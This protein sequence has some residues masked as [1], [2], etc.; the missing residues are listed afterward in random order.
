MRKIVATIACLG[1]TEIYAS[2]E[3]QAIDNV[4]KLVEN[5]QLH[6]PPVIPVFEISEQSRE[7]TPATE[8]SSIDEKKDKSMSLEEFIQQNPGFFGNGQSENR[9][10]E[11]ETDLLSI[12]TFFEM[13]LGVRESQ[14]TDPISDDD[15]TKA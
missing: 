12:I 4:A 5:F 11:V 2:E 1:I 15:D 14:P 8:Q 7:T 13:A 6:I 3:Q 9:V 10:K